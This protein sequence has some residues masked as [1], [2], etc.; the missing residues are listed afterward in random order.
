MR[1]PFRE[2]AEQVIAAAASVPANRAEGERRSGGDRLYHW[3]VAYGSA[4]ELAIHLTL[5]ERAG[6]VDRP[7][8]EG[9]RAL[10]DEVRAMLWRMTHAR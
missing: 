6:A 3:R 1:E 8:A 10:P 5:L 9:L 4:L 2:L 7:A